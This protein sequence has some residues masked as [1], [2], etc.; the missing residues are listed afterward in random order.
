MSYEPNYLKIEY[1]CPQEYEVFDR[2]FI[3][4]DDN[5]DMKKRRCSVS[6]DI[7]EYPMYVLPDLLQKARIYW[8]CHSVSSKLHAL[9]KEGRNKDTK[10][11]WKDLLYQGEL[12]YN[13]FGLDRGD[14]DR[15]F[16][17]A[18]IKRYIKEPGVMILLANAYL[19]PQMKKIE[20]NG[21]KENSDIVD[22]WPYLE[23]AVCAYKSGETVVKYVQEYEEFV[24][25][26]VFKEAEEL[27]EIWNIIFNRRYFNPFME[28][29]IM[30]DEEYEDDERETA[31]DFLKRNLQVED[32]ELQPF[33]EKVEEYEEGEI[34]AEEFFE[35]YI[36]YVRKLNMKKYKD[37]EDDISE[38]SRIIKS[39]QEWE[40]GNRRGFKRKMQQLRF[41]DYL[42]DIMRVLCNYCDML[43]F[44]PDS[45]CYIWWPDA[46][47]EKENSKDSQKLRNHFE[48]TF[49]YIWYH[50]KMEKRMNINDIE[51]VEAYY[52][53]C[54]ASIN[55]FLN[56]NERLL[57]SEK[58]YITLYNFEK[59][60]AF[61]LFDVE[62][63]IIIDELKNI[64]EKEECE[65]N[66]I[67][68]RM[69]ILLFEMFI[70]MNL[71]IFKDIYDSVGVYQRVLLAENALKDFVHRYYEDP[72]GN[73]SGQVYIY[74]NGS[75]VASVTDKIRQTNQRFLV[76]EEQM[77]IELGIPWIRGK[78]GGTP[79]EQFSKMKE[80]SREHE[81]V[82][83]HKEF[84]D[85][86]VT[87]LA[88]T[89]KKELN[90]RD[91][92][93]CA[94]DYIKEKDG[95]YVSVM[96]RIIKASIKNNLPDDLDEYL[97]LKWKAEEEKA[98]KKE[99][100]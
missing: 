5:D 67:E 41:Y 99:I 55:D 25:F 53:F 23:R 36:L 57:W 93:K 72:F 4:K 94:K 15:G 61:H 82:K 27:D 78:N 6:A 52:S 76:A 85:K 17:V 35:E 47:F 91:V 29:G 92:K 96:S 60:F 19:I 43:P 40:D 59:I 20:K 11:I 73:A 88:D 16:C 9:G 83:Q 34:N 81:L 64:C 95:L 84:Y 31:F 56:N 45:K 69:K 21:W 8:E 70:Q 54:F 89:N 49:R 1:V 71:C 18:E 77:I 13:Q 50:N 97:L 68:K 79:N 30:E 26:G 22:I 7:E 42:Q 3:Q 2:L 10:D 98:E 66:V 39:N 51:F 75:A 80:S 100:P 37:V 58:E 46:F 24:P 14:F 63:R 86:I 87:I 65:Q 28:V 90:K 38:I 12:V 44:F 48:L 32:S 33:K 74:S 62:T